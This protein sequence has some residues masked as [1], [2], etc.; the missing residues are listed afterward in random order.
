M[1]LPHPNCLRWAAELLASFF[2]QTEVAVQT[3]A[4]D[5][6]EGLMTSPHLGLGLAQDKPPP[7][8]H[9]AFPVTT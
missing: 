9:R 6:E 3:E 1:L 4:K 2:L 8:V 5:R 7:P